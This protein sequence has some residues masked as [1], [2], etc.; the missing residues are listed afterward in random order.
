MS[1]LLISLLLASLATAEVVNGGTYSDEKAAVRF[2][3][4]GGRSGTALPAEIMYADDRDQ[5]APTSGTFY[6]FDDERHCFK[7][8]FSELG[9]TKVLVVYSKPKFPASYCIY[10][11]KNAPEISGFSLFTTNGGICRPTYSE[12][13][14]ADFN[15]DPEDEL[16]VVPNTVAIRHC[17]RNTISYGETLEKQQVAAKA[18]ADAAKAAQA[19]KVPE[20]PKAPVATAAPIAAPKASPTAAP[21]AKATPAPTATPVAK[22]TVAPTAA[23]KAA[24]VVAA[25]TPKPLQTVK[26]EVKATPKVEAKPVAKAEPK[27]TVAPKATAAPVVAATPKSPTK[28]VDTR[29]VSEPA[30]VAAASPAPAASVAPMTFVSNLFKKVTGKSEEKAAELAKEVKKEESKPVVAKETKPVVTKESKPV[31][32]KEVKEVAKTAPATTDHRPPAAIDESEI[33][34]HKY[35]LQ[36][37]SHAKREQAEKRVADLRSKGTEAFILTHTLENGTWHRV[38][39]GTYDDMKSAQKGLKDLQENGQPES[40]V[41]MIKPRQ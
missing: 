6:V 20:V 28:K 40:F 9:A 11:K 25:A 13:S 22:A 16:K 21:V 39:V 34:K 36:I 35:T 30:K 37:S 2:E 3:E 33:L 17:V 10:Q 38:C 19:A 27:A 18:T 29:T 15:D 24:P 8:K 14:I 4:L 26:P 12:A 5:N 32:K 41:Q 23:P 31:A 1:P 7:A